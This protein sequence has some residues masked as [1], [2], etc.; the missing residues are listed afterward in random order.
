M[1]LVLVVL[2]IAMAITVPS[3]RGWSA[4]GKLRNTAQEFL[5][6]T[7]FA[8]TQAASNASLF[9]IEVDA[10]TSG[11]RVTT[12]DTDGSTWLPAAGEFG[13]ATTPSHLIRL[14]LDGGAGGNMIDF[15]P[16][17]RVTPATVRFTD[18]LG[19]YIDVISE[20]PAEPFRMVMSP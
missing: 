12:L 4:R 19:D 5:A 20:V 6:A 3:L 8:R 11:Y 2:A 15:Y 17:G 13:S 18:T 9:R 14:Q 10:S 1:I 16:N 7:Q